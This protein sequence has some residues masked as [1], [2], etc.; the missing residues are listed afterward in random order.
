MTRTFWTLLFTFACVSSQAV[1]AAVLSR[2][3]K[4]PGDGLLT[5]DEVNQR[6]WLDLTESDLSLF[7]GDSGEEKYANALAALAPHG[8]L[9]AQRADLTAL[10]QSAGIN[11]TTTEYLLNADS[12]NDLID[13]VGATFMNQHRR[14]A[15]GLLDERETFSGTRFLGYLEVISEPSPRAGLFIFPAHT[16]DPL[17]VA[18]SI[19]LYRPVP[20]PG[21][22]T[23]I[24]IAV[25]GKRF[26]AHRRWSGFAS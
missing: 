19:W 11:T 10:V 7:A 16:V 26:V 2:D 9:G 13:L 22:V 5:Y 15:D 17:S 6:E 21:G 23:L 20:E 14:L 24:L 18:P 4:M 12:T 25:F 3:W 8:F 1:H